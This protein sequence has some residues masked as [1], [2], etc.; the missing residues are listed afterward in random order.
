MDKLW[1]YLKHYKK[2]SILAPAFKLL[3]ALMDLLV[4]I[5][6]AAIINRGIAQ[7]NFAYVLRCF[8]ILL[9]L[10]V[11]GMLFSFTAQ[12]F[13]ATASV[14]AATDLRQALFDHIQS[15][16][17]QEL[18][19]LGTDTLITRITSDVNQVQTGINMTLRLMLRSPFIVFGSMI[20][21]FTID[22]R[23]A[24][25]FVVAIPLL[26]IVVFGIMAASIPLFKKVQTELDG[27]L[28]LTRENL[29]GVRVV[30]AFCK[31]AESIQEF[32]GQNDTLTRVNEFV[33]KLSALMNPLTYVL[34][35]FATILLIWQGGVRVNTGNLA[36]GDVVALYNYMAQIIVEL[37]KLASLIITINKSIACA[38]RVGSILDVQPGMAYPAAASLETSAIASDANA[39]ASASSPSRSESTATASANRV[40]AVEMQHVGLS[41]KGS[42]ADAVTDINFRAMPGQTIGIIGGTGSGKSTVVNLIARF[43]DATSG[44]VLVDGQDVREYPEGALI[45]KIGVVPQKA[46]LFEGSIRDNLRWG[47]A[48]ATDE[49]LWNAIRTAQAEEVI[50]GKDGMLDAWIEQNGRNL[51]G[52]QRQRLTI[53]RALVK[54]PEILIMDDSASALD[55]ATDLRLRTAIHGL[56]GE[57]TVFIVSQRTS[58]VRTADQILVLDDGQLVGLGT[59]NELMQ[60]CPVYQEIYYSQFPEERPEGKEQA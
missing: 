48:N 26:S 40:P 52:G 42:G 32:D 56:E 57:M 59:H 5:T 55:F 46:V 8:G 50:R 44:K 36:Q 10:A 3:E 37:I 22:V 34:I 23:C 16:S 1:D 18:D 11:L 20:M 2:E 4:P 33:G 41:Y 14:G 30:R 49:D 21:A 24:L 27:L 12:W 25:I 38:N 7:Q 53:A 17:Y 35:N 51:S 15:L 29:T 60:S 28:R 43:Y 39:A 13:A 45:H 54:K 19:V 31:E 58:S 9:L 47:N 6:V